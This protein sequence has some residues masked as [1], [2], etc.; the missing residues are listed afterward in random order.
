MTRGGRSL[1]TTPAVIVP[2]ESNLYGEIVSRNLFVQTP[3]DQIDN[4]VLGIVGEA[5]EIADLFKKRRFHP[6]KGDPVESYNE[7]MREIRLELGDVLFY[8]AL[9]NH[10]LFGDSLLEVAKDNIFKLQKRWTDRYKE[11]VTKMRL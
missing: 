9:L 10:N 8:L 5:G 1:G 4:A 7:F 6:A 2:P 11:D 3:V